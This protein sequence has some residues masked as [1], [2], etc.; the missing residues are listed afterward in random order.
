MANS[1]IA[2]LS[3]LSHEHVLTMVAAFDISS[4]R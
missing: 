1:E 2:I 4:K 3:E